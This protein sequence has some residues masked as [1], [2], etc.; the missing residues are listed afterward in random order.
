MLLNVLHSDP[1]L[2]EEIKLSA[3]PMFQKKTNGSFETDSLL[4]NEL[5]EA[6]RKLSMSQSIAKDL[7]DIIDILPADEYIQA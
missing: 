5:I 7:L 1:R 3:V 4:K 2:K 6:P